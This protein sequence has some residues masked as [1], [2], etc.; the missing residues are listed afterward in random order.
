MQL[1]RARPSL[2]SS[3]VQPRSRRRCQSLGSTSGY[4]AEGPGQDQC[5]PRVNSD[6]SLYEPFWCLW[7][8]MPPVSIMVPNSGPAPG[9]CGDLQSAY[10]S[11]FLRPSYA[12]N[13]LGL[14]H[15]SAVVPV[16]RAN[17]AA[18]W[19]TLLVLRRRDPGHW[20]KGAIAPVVRPLATREGKASRAELE[21]HLRGDAVRRQ[22][23]SGGGTDDLR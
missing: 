14:R 21:R 11:G 16:L 2:P 5:L 8:S 9:H 22:A 7:C 10:G 20:Q 3:L 1:F 15:V 6:K 23:A 18:L 4:A 12:P 17:D 13:P 19:L